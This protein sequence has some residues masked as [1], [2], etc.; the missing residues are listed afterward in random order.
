MSPEDMEFLF[1]ADFEDPG[2]QVVG[3]YHSHPDNA[4]YFS[5]KDREE[6][7]VGW[8]E[9]EPFYLVLS[10]YRHRVLDWKAFRYVENEN[11]FEECQLVVEPA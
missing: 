1:Q 2:Q 7:L 6:A 4:A 3:L 5:E 11:Q 9:P 10:V 8:I